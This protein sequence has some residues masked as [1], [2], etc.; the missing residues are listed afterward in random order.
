MEV[1]IVV[2]VVLFGGG[3]VDS[4]DGVCGVWYRYVEHPGGGVEQLNLCKE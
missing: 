2:V 3:G 1:L 4:V